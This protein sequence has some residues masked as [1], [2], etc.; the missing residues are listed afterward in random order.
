ML[1]GII[2]GGLLMAA[3]CQNKPATPA[4]SA[5]P[6]GAPAAA[7]AKAAPADPKPADPKPAVKRVPASPP[8][9]VATRAAPM[10]KTPVFALADGEAII[11]N[12]A[13]PAPPAETP[14]ARPAANYIWIPGCWTWGGDHYEWAAGHWEIPPEGETTWIPPRW[15]PDAD[16]Y[17]FYAG[18]WK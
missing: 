10:S 9:S 18:Y 1:M 2:S 14:P 13:P 3:G 5:R 7:V 8:R 17:R 11:I 12:Q 4:A 16:G 15:K 6:M